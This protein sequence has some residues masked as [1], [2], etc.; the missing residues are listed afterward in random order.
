MLLLLLLSVGFS[1]GQGTPGVIAQSDKPKRPLDLPV[2]DL[3][4]D[5]EEDEPEPDTIFFYGDGYEAD[6]FF[7]LLDRSGSMNHQGRLGILKVEVLQ[8]IQ[9]LSHASEFGIVAF[10]SNSTKFA[11]TPVRARPESKA[12]AAAWVNALGPAGMSCLAPAAT[13]LI[14]ISNQC[15][16][17]SKIIFIVGDGSPNCPLC[18]AT[19]ETIRNANWQRTPVNTIYIGPLSDT[20]A[21]DCFQEI[22]ATNG[23]TFRAIAP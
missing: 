15:K 1:S 22:A 10:S 12:Q 21:A 5:P 3:G 13:K 16:K 2:G 23:G 4:L 8:A 14:N 20:I 6:G 17:A 9:G 7:W 18:P 11:Q 19:I